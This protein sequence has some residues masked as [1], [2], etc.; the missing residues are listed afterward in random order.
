MIPVLVEWRFQAASDTPHVIKSRQQVTFERVCDRT[1][2][3]TENS[4]TALVER[5][6][7]QQVDLRSSLSSSGIEYCIVDSVFVL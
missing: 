6:R 7:I 3:A 5:V 4:Q 2:R 1:L